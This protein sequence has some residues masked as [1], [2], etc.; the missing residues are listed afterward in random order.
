MTPPL[1]VLGEELL[2]Q[3]DRALVRGD[4]E[5]QVVRDVVALGDLDEDLRG[6]CGV[7]RGTGGFCRTRSS[8]VV[9]IGETFA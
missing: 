3:A 7:A 5:R 4:A 2:V 9:S 6:A 8:V 1:A